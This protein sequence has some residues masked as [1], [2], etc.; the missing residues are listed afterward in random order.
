MDQTRTRAQKA[1]SKSG[2]GAKSPCLDVEGEEVG[3]Q[4]PNEDGEERHQVFAHSKKVLTRSGP[5]IL[6]CY[7]RFVF[8]KKKELGCFEL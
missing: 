4:A 8:A 1:G 7:T 5:N 2:H 6:A 3:A